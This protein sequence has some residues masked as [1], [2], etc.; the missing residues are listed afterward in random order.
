MI[1]LASVAAKTEI[2]SRLD[3]Y[4]REYASAAPYIAENSTL[5]GLRLHDKLEGRLFPAKVPVF[6]Q[7]SSRIASIRH[8]VDLKN[9]QGQSSDH[10]IQ[11]RPGVAATAALGGN[12][13]ITALPPRVDLMAYERQ[14]GRAIDYVLLHGFRDAVEDKVALARLDAQLRDNYKLVYVSEPR[15]FVHLYA[16]SSANRPANAK[17]SR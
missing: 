3:G 9:F 8:S 17:Q 7:A 13:A 15:G 11:L 14:M 4:Y 12:L 16:R 6:I 1:L 5:I 2:F 10:P